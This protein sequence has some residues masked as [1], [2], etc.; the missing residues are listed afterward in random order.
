MTVCPLCLNKI[1]FTQITGPDHRIFLC[2]DKCKLVFT[3]TSFLPSRKEEEKRYKKHNDGIQLPGYV[4]F[5]N[6]AI[7]PALPF[8]SKEMKGLDYGCG[9]V[10]TLSVLLER[11]GIGCENYDSLFFPELPDGPF[12]FI[13]ATECFE[14]F[15]LPAR[16]MQK[17]K[18]LLKP[19]GFLI[20]MT[21]KWTKPEEF[22]RWS[23]AKDTTHVTFYH[24]DTFRFIS[25]K[26]K[27][28]LIESNNPR[29]VMLQKEE[30]EAE[31]GVVECII[32]EGSKTEEK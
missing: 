22:A 17:I 24:A 12:D 6:Q 11:Q 23:Y 7:E 13:F 9:P 27:F 1:A 2:C 30:I 29:V 3:A 4:K 15:F 14:Y 5:L 31:V 25:A 10:P 16:E 21:E 32:P 19:Q 20:V 28:I 18:N 8:L 26:Y